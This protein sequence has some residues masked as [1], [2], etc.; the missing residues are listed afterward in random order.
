MKADSSFA[1]R[2]GQDEPNFRQVGTRTTNGRLLLGAASAH[3]GQ[4]N[5][6]SSIPSKF[7][8]ILYQGDTEADGFASRTARFKPEVRDLP[9]PGAY[10]QP[11]SMNIVSDSLSKKGYG[12]GFVSKADRFRYIDK[13]G[14]PAY[15]PGPGAYESKK[16]DQARWKDF[17]RTETTS[18]F[19]QKDTKPLIPVNRYVPGP[20]AYNVDRLNRKRRNRKARVPENHSMSLRK[21]TTDPNVDGTHD[22]GQPGTGDKD[23]RNQYGPVGG[24]K[25]NT[26]TD[27]E[28]NA[29]FGS[30]KE[31]FKELKQDFPGP[32]Q[33]KPEIAQK[34]LQPDD[35]S[36]SFK[37]ST[38]RN[39]IDVD[40]ARDDPG[41]GHYYPF[42]H[43][44]IDRVTKDEASWQSFKMTQNTRFGVPKQR[45]TQT[46]EVPG[47]GHYQHSPHRIRGG[48]PNEYTAFG[49]TVNETGPSQG[50]TEATKRRAGGRPL[51]RTTASI[52]ASLQKDLM[53]TSKVKA[54]GPAYYTSDSS[55]KDKRSFLLNAQNRWV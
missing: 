42:E 20:G 47:P 14:C 6:A 41:P 16:V 45:R 51:L 26:N 37:S 5:S 18:L 31:R 11:T 24:T 7:E 38:V 27:R 4:A 35:P 22:I 43:E 55:F 2:G 28:G 50:Y 34:W 10:H 25:L 9:G 36:A 8:T 39:I 54:P 33:Y 48:T 12:N 32:G 1:S 23:L 13:G 53:A 49:S 40:A 21:A 52:S 29:N 44:E 15:F 17:N 19:K 30:T 3:S 46:H